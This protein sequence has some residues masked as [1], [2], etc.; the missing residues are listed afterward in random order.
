MKHFIAL[1]GQNVGMLVL[2]PA[3]QT[4]KNNSLKSYGI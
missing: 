2:K 3:L 4:Q 1:R